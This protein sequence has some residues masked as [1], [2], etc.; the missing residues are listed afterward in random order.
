MLKEHLWGCLGLKFS[1]PLKSLNYEKETEVFF[2]TTGYHLNLWDLENGLQ[3][4]NMQTYNLSS[5]FLAQIYFLI[6]QQYAM[7]SLKCEY[8]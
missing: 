2:V 6:F 8:Y 3:Q 7:N 1:T 4:E 5:P